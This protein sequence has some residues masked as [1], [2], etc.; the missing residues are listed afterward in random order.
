MKYLSKL[1]DYFQ[2]TVLIRDGSK[3]LEKTCTGDL[4]VTSTS[5]DPAATSMVTLMG[6]GEFYFVE[7]N[8]K[9][10]KKLTNYIRALSHELSAKQAREHKHGTE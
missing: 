3:Q 6:D 2:A 1:P 4:Y 8:V 10:S 9:V 5:G 7:A